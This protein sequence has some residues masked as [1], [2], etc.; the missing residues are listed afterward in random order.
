MDCG[1]TDNTLIAFIDSYICPFRFRALIIYICEAG[2]IIERFLAD[3]RD[4]VGDSYARETFASTECPTTYARYA[5]GNHY[6]R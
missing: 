2:A 3:A 1:G 6:A 4:A 5:A